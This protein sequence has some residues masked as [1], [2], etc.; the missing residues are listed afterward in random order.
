MKN[1]LL[2][3]TAGTI[4]ASYIALSCADA[5]G[6]SVPDLI[7]AYATTYG[8]PLWRAHGVARCESGYLNVP[9]RQGS[10]ASG[11]YQFMPGTWRAKS[12]QAGWGGW[13]VWDVEANVATAMFV[14]GVQ[15]ELWHWRACL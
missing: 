14:M 9:N 3:F 12:W 4:L 11:I 6:Q 10:G 13:S 1:W 2:G 5:H 7:D 8:V 15:R